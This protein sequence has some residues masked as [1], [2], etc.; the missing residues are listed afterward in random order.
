MNLGIDGTSPSIASV[1]SPSL[2]LEKN[3]DNAKECLL[4][5]NETGLS[6]KSLDVQEA[7]EACEAKVQKTRERIEEVKQEIAR[8]EQTYDLLKMDKLH[9]GELPKLELDLD[10]ELRGLERQQILL[11]PISK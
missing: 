5:S 1:S 3:S 4:A 2:A 11:E 9:Y 6:E 8:A 7:V 10:E